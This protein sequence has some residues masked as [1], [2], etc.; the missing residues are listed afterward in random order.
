MQRNQLYLF[1]IISIIIY[2]S[3]LANVLSTLY[4]EVRNSLE[5]ARIVQISKALA[6]NEAM[7]SS[8]EWLRKSNSDLYLIPIIVYSDTDS[9]QNTTITLNTSISDMLL[10]IPALTSSNIT[11]VNSELRE[12]PNSVNVSTT[13]DEIS[14]NLTIPSY[15][16]EY[17]DKYYYFKGYVMIGKFS[18]TNF[19]SVGG[20][21]LE[22]NILYEVLQII[23][24][25]DISF[26][27]FLNRDFAISVS[28]EGIRYYQRESFNITLK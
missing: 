15:D 8:L 6:F 2:L 10:T 11:I 3:T 26:L 18:R 28:P 14:I 27:N 20:G 7:H 17:S 1:T 23:S 12:I 4:T 16:W 13:W 21:N 24:Q 25:R 5:N 22:H 19:G 9:T